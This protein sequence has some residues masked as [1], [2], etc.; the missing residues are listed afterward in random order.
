MGKVNKNGIQIKINK[1]EVENKDDIINF[2]NHKNAKLA[3]RGL[4]GHVK[5]F[6]GYNKKKGQNQCNYEENEWRYVV[7]QSDDIPWFWDNESYEKWRGEGEKPLPN[8]LLLDKK[9][10]FNVQ[11]I[12]F[13]IIEK[14]EQLNR[15]IEKIEKL[16]YIGGNEQNILT[17][18]DRS[19]LISRIISMEHIKS[20]F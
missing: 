16:P 1:N 15:T 3:N 20:N 10:K 5:R 12:N 7:T 14:E 13:I 2:F 8:D 17:D 4:L 11:D 18:D 19:I 6:T 9:L